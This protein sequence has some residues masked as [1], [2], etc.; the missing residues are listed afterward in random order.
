MSLTNTVILLFVGSAAAWLALHLLTRRRRRRRLSER[1]RQEQTARERAEEEGRRAKETLESELAAL[2]KRFE[3]ERGRREREEGQDIAARRRRR[4]EEEEIKRLRVE[5]RERE[6]DALRKRVEEEAQRRHEAEHLAGRAEEEARR[7]REAEEARRLLAERRASDEA[8]AR[9]RAEAEARNRI[10]EE[11]RRR[12]EAEE[13]ARRAHEARVRAEEEAHTSRERAERAAREMRKRRWFQNDY[14]ERISRGGGAPE[15]R[16][17][18]FHALWYRHIQAEVWVPL[19]VYMYSGW[20]G[21]EGA[22]ADFRRRRTAPPEHYADSASEA[23]VQRGAEI[24]VVPELPGF[25][26]N[27]PSARILWLEE[28]HCIEFRMQ[29]LRTPPREGAEHVQGRVAFFVGPL[30]IAEIELAVNVSDG[31]PAPQA[32]ARPSPD[33]SGEGDFLQETSASVY[34]TIFVSYSHED[35]AIV[36][37]LERAYKA[38]GDSY[39]RDV[40]ILRSGEEWSPALLSKI[41]GADVFQLCWSQTAKQSPHVEQEW[42][43]ALGLRRANFVRPMFWEK[44]MPDPP[45]DLAHIHFTFVDMSM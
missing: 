19:L 34:R 31:A 17:V 26:F 1:R 8:E 44:P 20:G 35:T 45:P 16:P 25:T 13:S 33:F 41:R 6:L 18:R 27:P 21:Y 23:A 14:G 36:R 39:L 28:W 32:P 3:E 5:E 2:R 38:I 9:K 43:C 10:E 42:K 12:R 15:R 30:L 4:H 7:R 37:Q 24:T 11:E 22:C 29:A 40:D